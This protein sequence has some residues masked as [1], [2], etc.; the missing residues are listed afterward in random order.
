MTAICN[1]KNIELVLSL[2]ADEVIEFL[3]ED[4]TKRGQTYEVVLDAVGKHSYFRSRRALEP[5]GKFAATDRLYNL[6][7]AILTRLA[8]KKVVFA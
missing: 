4:F 2:G 1:T 7:L 8:R 5:H 6:P 3:N